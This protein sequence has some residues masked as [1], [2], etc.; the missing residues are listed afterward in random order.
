MREQ[1]RHANGWTWV[2][3]ERADGDVLVASVEAPDGASHPL[4]AVPQPAQTRAWFD[5]RLARAQV[6]A[7]RLVAALTGHVRCHADCE[8]W[9]RSPPS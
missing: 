3:E 8:S 4:A 6:T 1:R 7:D 2:V 5:T 9:R